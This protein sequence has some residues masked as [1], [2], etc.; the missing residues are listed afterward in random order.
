[1]QIK[2]F[3]VGMLEANCYI[4][5]QRYSRECYVIDP[6]SDH[7]KIAKFIRQ[8]GLQLKAII[9]T[10]GHIDHFGGVK[11]LQELIPCPVY[12]NIADVHNYRFK[13]DGN[14][15]DGQTLDLAGEKIKVLS[16]PGHT[17]GSV[18]FYSEKSGIAFT[19]DTIFDIDIG[20]MDLPGGST[21]DMRSSLLN[22]VNKWGNE[23]I[24]YPGHGDSSSM[25]R[26]R[27]INHEFL[28]MIRELPAERDGHRNIIRSTGDEI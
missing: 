26:V 11:K 21:E 17:G 7:E 6:G 10:H 23:I 22:V 8:E 15:E 1:M 28:E 27:E 9:L 24:I 4:I 18:C 12:L 14:L 2:R 3:I 19:G 16:T 20:R 25:K 5:Y 13:I